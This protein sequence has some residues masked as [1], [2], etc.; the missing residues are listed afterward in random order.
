[1]LIKDKQSIDAKDFLVYID[2]VIYDSF[3]TTD[4]FNAIL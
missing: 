2:N 4:D 1:M 3:N